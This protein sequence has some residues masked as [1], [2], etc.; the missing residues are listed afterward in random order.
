MKNIKRK[1]IIATAIL[2]FSVAAM[3]VGA[4]YAADA[5]AGKTDPMSGLV[6]AIAQKFN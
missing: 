6:N 3:G 1:Y 2:I 5:A 4:V